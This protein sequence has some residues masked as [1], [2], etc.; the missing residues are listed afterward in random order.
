MWVYD[1]AGPPLL[2]QAP[3]Q[4]AAL[5]V[6]YQANAVNVPRVVPDSPPPAIPIATNQLPTNVTAANYVIILNAGRKK[7]R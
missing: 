3:Q 4:L 1:G 6:A 5:P 2:V 7:V